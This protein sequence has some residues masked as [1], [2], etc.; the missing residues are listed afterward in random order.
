MNCE[1]CGKAFGTTRASGKTKRF[2]SETCRSA[3]EKRRSKRK[4]RE[5]RDAQ[6]TKETGLHPSKG[7]CPTCG[8]VFERYSDFESRQGWRKF[9]ST[10]C[11]RKNEAAKR[12][13]KKKK[14]SERNC[15]QCGTS[16]VSLKG[17]VCSD[18]CKQARRHDKSFRGHPITREEFNALERA[19]EDRCRICK[20]EKPLV[21]DH[22]HTEGHVR[23]LLCAQCNSGL[24]MFYDNIAYL[25][26]AIEYLNFT[27]SP[28]NAGAD[29]KL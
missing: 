2:C 20:Q 14:P 23:G 12:E 7:K 26:E 16:F 1:R 24:G 22:C 21:I 10:E 17:K 27:K 9:C 3:E 6:Y 15:I 28:F 25:S 19:Q 29:R 5:W 8:V 18:A 11:Q 4:V 13:K